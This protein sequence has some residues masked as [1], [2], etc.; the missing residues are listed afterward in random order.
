MEEKK[1]IYEKL[2]FGTEQMKEKIMQFDQINKDYH[3]LS[4]LL[5]E[6]EEFLSSD[7]RIAKIK[8]TIKTIKVNN[9]SIN[10]MI[11]HCNHIE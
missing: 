10:S 3:V 2:T 11:I 5:R 6:K 4:A 8:N 1:K 9:L 7:K